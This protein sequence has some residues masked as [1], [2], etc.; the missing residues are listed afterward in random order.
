MTTARAAVLDRPR[1]TFRVETFAL[2]DP[3]P[4]TVLL[5]MELAGCCATDAHAYLGQ[6][7]TEF[8]VVMGHEN[9]GIVAALGAGGVRDHSGRELRVGDRV[10]AR[11]S[12]C[13]QCPE[14]RLRLPRRCRTKRV[15]YGY[16]RLDLA[17]FSGGYAEYLY[18]SSPATTFMARIDLPASVAALHEPLGWPRTRS[19][20]RRRGSATRWWCREAARS[21]SSPPAS[22]GWRGRRGSSSWAGR[23]S[24]WSSPGPSAPT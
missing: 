1:G 9:V 8:P 15:S 11:T 12:A 23:P 2:P 17:P 10:I 22:R 7:A 21:A 6:W 5:R 24:V 13:G 4:G 16:T 20:G 14:C 19:G 3:A 18:L